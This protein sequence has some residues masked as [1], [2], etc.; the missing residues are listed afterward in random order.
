MH[1]RYGFDIGI[2]FQ[3]E[4]AIVT[5]MDVHPERHG[6]IVEHSPFNADPS[7]GVQSFVDA[8]GNV[9][10]RILAPAGA[11]SMRAEGIVAS[12]PTRANP[13]S[14][15]PMLTQQQYGIC[16]TTCCRS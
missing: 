13:T 4:T 11:F 16:R 5:L 3:Q 12:W 15:P 7:R 14:K 9:A 6:D 8:F 1:I 10:R 2:S